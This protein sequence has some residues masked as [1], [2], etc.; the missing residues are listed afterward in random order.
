MTRLTNFYCRR[1]FYNKTPLTNFKCVSMNSLN[2]WIEA[3]KD[4]DG[5]D[6]SLMKLLSFACAEWIR[7]TR[8]TVVDANVGLSLFLSSKTEYP[9]VNW[10]QS[11]VDFASDI[12]DFCEKSKEL[13]LPD[14]IGVDFPKLLD[15]RGVKCPAN[16]VRSRLVMAGL[17]EGF[18][19]EI[20]LDEGSPIENVPQALVADGHFIKKREKNGLFW[21]IT[22]VKSTSML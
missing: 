14:S 11:P 20:L 7:R 16:A 15:L 18:E 1:N 12:V 10:V 2:C 4:K 9:L 6:I 22:V 17:P 19:L 13:P 8:G 5:F 3:N 21:Q